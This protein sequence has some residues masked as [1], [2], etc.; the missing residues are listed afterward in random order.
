MWRSNAHQGT[1]ASEALCWTKRMVGLFS[2]MSGGEGC[3]VWGVIGKVKICRRQSKEHPRVMLRGICR[4]LLDY[5]ESPLAP[6][7]GNKN[8]Q[9]KNA[10]KKSPKALESNKMSQLSVN[11]NI[12]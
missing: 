11:T 8:T 1:E 3:R 2:G 4:S 7:L 5:M 10:K 6:C 9:M 12:I